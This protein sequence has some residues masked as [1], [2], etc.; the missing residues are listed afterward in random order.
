MILPMKKY[1]FIVHHD[2]YKSFLGKLGKLGV[3]HVIEREDI[4][5]EEPLKKDRKYLK[6]I[7]KALNL[8]KADEP[9]IAT[10][11]K[12]HTSASGTN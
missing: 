5:K 2:D 7:D 6:R 8:I 3:M 11:D 9:T 4:D 10:G 12:K 1:S